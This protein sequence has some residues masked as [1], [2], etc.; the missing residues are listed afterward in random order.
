MTFHELSPAQWRRV[1]STAEL[2][3]DTS[4]DLWDDV[5]RVE[6]GSDEDLRQ[7]ALRLARNFD[8]SPSLFGCPSLPKIQQLPAASMLQPG[9]RVGAYRIEREVGR[10]TMGCVYSATRADDAFDKQ[11][12]IKVLALRGSA[13]QARFRAEQ[14]IH[15][16]LEH[17]CIARLHDAGVTANGSPYIVME[18]VDGLPLDAYCLM[19]GLDYGAAVRLVHSVSAA[20]AHA[21]RRGVVHRDLKPGNILVNSSGVPKLL[22]FGIAA[23][24]SVPK[25]AQ[26][27]GFTPS[28]ASPEQLSGNPGNA[29]SDVYSLAAVLYR[30]LTG[31]LPTRPYLHRREL[32][33]HPDIAS[34]LAKGLAADP[35]DRY[36]SAVEFSADLERYLTGFPV[37]SRPLTWGYRSLRFL[38]RHR[39]V[40]ILSAGMLLVVAAGAAGVMWQWERLHFQLS[41]TG[42]M[43]N[44]LLSEESAM[45]D[46]PGTV[47]IRKSLVSKMLSDLQS[48]SENYASDPVLAS[49]FADAYLRIG[50]VQ[51]VPGAPG[52]GDYAASALSF[53]S[54]RSIAE[55]IVRRWP[56]SV[57]GRELLA[58]TLAYQ[59][60]L[61]GWSGKDSECIQLGAQANDLFRQIPARPE[62]SEAIVTN[63]NMLVRCYTKA[64]QLDA[65]IRTASAWVANEEKHPTKPASLLTA[66]GRLARSL[67][68]ADRIDEARAAFQQSIRAQRRELAAR[69]GLGAS[70][71]L[72]SELLISAAVRPEVCRHPDD[73]AILREA[74]DLMTPILGADRRD[75]TALSLVADCQRCLGVDL[76]ANGEPRQGLTLLEENRRLLSRADPGGASIRVRL[77]D[78]W[79][80]TAT[81]LQITGDL[82]GAEAAILYAR[83]A[84]RQ[85]SP[86][87]ADDLTLATWHKAWATSA[88]SSNGCRRR[89]RSGANRWR[90]RGH[91]PETF[92]AET[93]RWCWRGRCV[94][95]D[96]A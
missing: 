28:Y 68:E 14:F 33:L 17:E 62:L 55:G 96:C 9:D 36:A 20:V 39:L 5:S 86:D 25:L 6:L 48:A 57:R 26:S 11:V 45:R 78:N 2:L 38:Q 73:R 35:S 60:S 44:D 77:A 85:G 19:H 54:A 16:N 94:P 3:L 7:V 53:R 21:H 49:T 50:I 72:A 32:H 70:M 76:A 37:R 66:Y 61:A 67:F 12:A 91:T 71:G 83:E 95:L 10:G 90:N 18:L 58:S 93:Q 82:A 84:L 41:M 23:M 75:S 43:V 1:K 59:E 34:I 4:P 42:R 8:D 92:P 88:L 22:D 52:F 87:V 56:K 46:V 13:A 40:A 51:G 47:E 29:R 27:S 24:E 74:V 79:T 80:E 15:A 69:P 30:L 31:R 63:L 81:A 64:G 89:L 65:A